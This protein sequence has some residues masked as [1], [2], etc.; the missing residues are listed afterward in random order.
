MTGAKRTLRNEKLA[1]SGS[2]AIQLQMGSIQARIGQ[3]VLENAI[4][5]EGQKISAAAY[6]IAVAP[7]LD[8]HCIAQYSR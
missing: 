3:L 2:F 8:L 1:F 6:S 5:D 7:R 4:D